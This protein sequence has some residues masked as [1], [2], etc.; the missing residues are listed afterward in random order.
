MRDWGGVERCLMKEETWPSLSSARTRLPIRGTSS[1]TRWMEGFSAGMVGSTACMRL[2]S[3]GDKDPKQRP[4]HPKSENRSAQ[5]K[6]TWGNRSP[7][8][9][10][11]PKHVG[12][13]LAP[14]VPSPETRGATARPLRPK[15]RNTLGNRF[16]QARN[17]LPP[18]PQALK[19]GEQPVGWPGKP[20]PS[21]GQAFAPLGTGLAP[22]RKP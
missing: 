16:P 1:V 3:A 19:P 12:R 22:R 9:S 14:C 17:R 7:L 4:K 8:A 10:R 18:A 21:P 20:V 5:P 11:A 13:R 6:N 2:P 15:P